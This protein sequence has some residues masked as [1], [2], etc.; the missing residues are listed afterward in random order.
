VRFSDVWSALAKRGSGKEST[1]YD[2]GRT[3]DEIPF[4]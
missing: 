3:I 2:H 4:A 1:A